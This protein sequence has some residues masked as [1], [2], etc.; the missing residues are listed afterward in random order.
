MADDLDERLKRAVRAM[1]GLRGEKRAVYAEDL[2][3]VL[4]AVELIKAARDVDDS[5]GAEYPMRPA[6]VRLRAA[7]GRPPRQFINGEWTC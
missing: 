2:D 3:D 5:I 7:L 6:V 1:A 4:Q